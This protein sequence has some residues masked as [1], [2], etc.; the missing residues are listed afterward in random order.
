MHLSVS[1]LDYVSTFVACGVGDVYIATCFGIAVKQK[2]TLFRTTQFILAIATMVSCVIIST[3]SPP[4][5]QLRE[6]ANV[7]F[8]R[9]LNSLCTCMEPV[10]LGALY[11]T[12][13]D[14]YRLG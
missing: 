13:S 4:E 9:A 12:I 11:D 8:L 14:H 10:R 7:N 6:Y 1:K 3:T 5:A 2:L